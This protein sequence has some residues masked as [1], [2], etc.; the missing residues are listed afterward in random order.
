ESVPHELLREEERHLRA[1]SRI[2]R[3]RNH[4]DV[5]QRQPARLQTV[6][7]GIARKHAVT[8]FEPREPLFFRERD[9]LTID[10]ECGG[11]LLDDAEQA[12]DVHRATASIASAA[13]PNATATSRSVTNR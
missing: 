10:E 1:G 7:G 5:L 13:G 4:V 8:G 6:R 11:G 12:Q 9:Q 3:P 2:P